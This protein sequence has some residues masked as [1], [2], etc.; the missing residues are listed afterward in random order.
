MNNTDNDLGRDVEHLALG[1]AVGYYANKVAK[2]ETQGKGLLPQP[3]PRQPGYIPAV[4]GQ[5]TVLHFLLPPILMALF[6]PAL[7]AGLLGF[8]GMIAGEN[9]LLLLTHLP[10]AAIYSMLAVLGFIDLWLVMKYW[11]WRVCVDR[12]FGGIVRAL[13]GEDAF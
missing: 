5:F 11:V 12:I 6:F 9:Q 4:A 2:G 7:I 10:Q 8:M 1:A 3:D 13:F